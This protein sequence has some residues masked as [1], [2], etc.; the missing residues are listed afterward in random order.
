MAQSWQFVA[1][2]PDGSRCAPSVRR[3]IRKNAMRSYHRSQRRQEVKDFQNQLRND[4]TGQVEGSPTLEAKLVCSSTVVFG[5]ETAHTRYREHSLHG[6][7]SPTSLQCWSGNWL[8]P[9]EQT[10]MRAPY[11]AQY[12]FM[13][14]TPRFGCHRTTC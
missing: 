10:A 4:L 1:V 2:H 14:C 11:D 5:A 8:D 12:L 6:K 7:D 13:H 9:F 3:L